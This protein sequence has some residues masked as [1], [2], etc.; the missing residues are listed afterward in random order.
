MAKIKVVSIPST[1]TRPAPNNLFAYNFEEI[2]KLLDYDPAERWLVEIMP[3]GFGGNHSHPRVESWI[4]IGGEI[5]LLWIENGKKESLTISSKEPGKLMLVTI[6][7][8]IPHVLRN[9]T[10]NAAYIMEFADSQMSDPEQFDVINYQ[11]K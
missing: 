4:V 7:P 5:Q 10:S 6:E 3:H 8:N 1:Y 2:E 9:T 11:S